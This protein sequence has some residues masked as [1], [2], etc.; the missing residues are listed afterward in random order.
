MAKKSNKNKKRSISLFDQA[1]THPSLEIKIMLL[2]MSSEAMRP[3]LSVFNI[4]MPLFRDILAYL[5]SLCDICSNIDD[6]NIDESYLK[7]QQMVQNN[8]LLSVYM[9]DFFGNHPYVA[10]SKVSILLNG[11]IEEVVINGQKD[12]FKT[13]CSQ[14]NWSFIKELELISTRS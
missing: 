13:L 7:L 1:M 5:K 10:R 6:E 8:E 2:S 14:F 9:M 12:E 4:P 11:L 3:L